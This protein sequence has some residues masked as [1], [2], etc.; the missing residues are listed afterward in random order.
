[1]IRTRVKL[2][3]LVLVMLSWS[4]PVSAQ[5]LQA[6]TQQSTLIFV[7]VQ[8]D[9]KFEGVFPKFRATVEFS[10][11]Q[12]Y[13]KV[14]A[15]IDMTAVDTENEERDE[16]LLSDDFFD[17]ERFPEAV[18]Q[19]QS[20]ELQKGQFVADGSLTIKQHKRPISMAFRFDPLSSRLTGTLAINRLDFEVGSGMWTDTTWIGAEVII[21]VDARLVPVPDS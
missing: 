9:A 17:A 20:V 16:Y 8:Q 14:R 12:P 13:F 3:G 11:A 1:M 15:V 2:F 5:T 6:D 19:A 10:E 18:F 4:F 7:A 21:Q